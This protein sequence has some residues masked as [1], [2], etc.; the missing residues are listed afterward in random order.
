MASSALLALGL[1][2]VYR[3][4]RILNFAQGDLGAAPAS[5]AVLLVVSSGAS[6]LVAFTTGILAAVV[7]GAAVEFL[8]IRRFFRSPRL[9][10]TVATIGLAQVLA[11]LGLL[12]PG[13]FGVVL[14][15][16]SFPAPVDV[17]FTIEPIR[18]G[19]NDL[20]AML[21]IP[22]A[23]V[24]LAV[25]LRTR[26]GVAMRACA[27]DVDRAALVGIPVRRVHSVVWMLAAVLG[28]L[29]VFL[30]AG[31]VGLSIG[32]VLGP[33]AAPPCAGGRGDRSDGTAAD[34]RARRHRPRDPGAGGAVG[35][36]PTERRRARPVRRRARRGVVDARGIGAPREDRA[37]G[38]AGSPRATPGAA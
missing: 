34:D 33:V 29:A 11:G 7:L 38:V 6:W 10:L 35:L 23:F 22:L 27:D 2:L 21:V 20:I 5:L 32:T 13:W 36:E 18:F 16:Q 1:A 17:S 28:F 4:N 19:G 37:V 31:I 24:G 30:R 14:P 15:P 12:L 8:V 3:A 9:I 26:L 25:F